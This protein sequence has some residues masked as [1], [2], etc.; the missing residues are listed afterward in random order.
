VCPGSGFVSTLDDHLL[1]DPFTGIALQTY[2]GKATN[3]DIYAN[4]Q[5]GGIVSALLAHA[6][7]SGEI[8]GVVT[9]V[10]VAGNPP[11]PAAKLIHAPEELW[12]AQ[13]SKYC[14]VP[15][16]S[17][18][19]EVEKQEHQI[20]FV[21]VGCQVHGLNNLCERFQSLKDKISFTIGLICDRTMTYGAIDYLLKRANVPSEDSKI[22]H[23]RDKAC[24]G[25]P[26]NVNVICSSG[27]SM[28]LPSSIRK[29]I[30]DFFTPAYCRICFDKMNV[31]SDITVGD[32]WGISGVDK[33]HGESIAVI[34]TES[35]RCVFQGALNAGAIAARE[36]DYRDV[37]RGQG[38]EKKRV[39]WHGYCE[40]WNQSGR[41]LP[42]CHEQI[43]KH[44]GP[45]KQK[46]SYKKQLRHAF[47]LDQYSSREALVAAAETKLLFQKV[48][49]KTAFPL[50]AMKWM[51]KRIS[52]NVVKGV[53]LC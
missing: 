3:K 2:V 9:V 39:D 15:L 52:N 12:N 46:K 26:G 40:A 51:L 30:K 8:A 13:K 4:S 38:I 44:S 6:L 10:M 41:T 16:L 17:I 20:A 31:L 36:I 35:G 7:K 47:S 37:L 28:S 23:F 53:R 50:R 21:G 29:D 43:R 27:I 48:R 42:S 33:V 49:K 1:Q 32:P 19:S 24:G 34:R 14:P 18:L 5:S 11:R 22:L 25:Y 45:Q